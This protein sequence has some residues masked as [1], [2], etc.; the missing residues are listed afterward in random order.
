VKM[1]KMLNF[2]LGFGWFYVLSGKMCFCL[3]T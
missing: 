1:S 2:A 3:T